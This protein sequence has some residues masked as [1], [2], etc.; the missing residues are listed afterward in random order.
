MFE[1]SLSSYLLLTLYLAAAAF[2]LFFRTRYVPG[3]AIYL[4]RV[5]FPSWRF[6][7][8][9]CELPVLYHRVRAADGAFGPWRKSLSSDRRHLY[10]L[11]FNAEGNKLLAYQGLLQQV[12]NDMQSVTE[13]SE[14]E[15]ASSVSYRLLE[16]LVR[17][18]IPRSELPEGEGPVFFQFRLSS[19]MQGEAESSAT[20]ILISL[21]HEY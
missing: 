11:L 12:E 18:Q 7:E 16:R 1:I 3:R 2:L 13:G 5:L 8:D 17:K 6:F 4:F 19:L 21:E 9:L 15:F 20:E 14:A 10:K